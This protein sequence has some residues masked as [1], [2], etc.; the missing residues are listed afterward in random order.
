MET[1]DEGIV[2]FVEPGG[3][4]DEE[5]AGDFE[6][7]KPAGQPGHVADEFVAGM[8]FLGGVELFLAEAGDG[9]VGG[10]EGF[11]SCGGKDV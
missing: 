11:V 2:F 10:F 1:D 9:L 5:I 8:D 7:A 6:D 4:V 3:F